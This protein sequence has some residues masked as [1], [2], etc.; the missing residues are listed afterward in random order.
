MPLLPGPRRRRATLR[1]ASPFDYRRMG[2]RGGVWRRAAAA[3]RHRASLAGRRRPRRGPATRRRRT[4]R[5]GSRGRRTTS[6][7]AATQH[8]DLYAPVR[9]QA[10]DQLLVAAALGAELLAIIAGHRLRLALAF[11][12]DHV[13]LRALLGEV[14]LH[15]LRARLGQ[16]LVEVLGSD[17]VSVAHGDDLVDIGALDLGGELIQALLA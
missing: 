16:L 17:A 9:L 5:P 2:A 6:H 13:G 12:R 7:L 1:P 11:G 14:V 15:R 4:G 10:G 3:H 8:F